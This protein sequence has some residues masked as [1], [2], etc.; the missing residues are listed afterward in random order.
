MITH[1]LQIHINMSHIND[2]IVTGHLINITNNNRSFNFLHSNSQFT[3]QWIF[4]ISKFIDNGDFQF[5]SQ[6][7]TI[8]VLILF[9]KFKNRN[10]QQYNVSHHQLWRRNPLELL[11]DYHHFQFAIITFIC[12]HCLQKFWYIVT[13]TSNL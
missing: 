4:S 2:K 1:R 8:W 10:I 13:I 5:S 6:Q 7:F 3:S 11:Q 9:R 12:G